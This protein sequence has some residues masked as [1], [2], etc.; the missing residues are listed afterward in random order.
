MLEKNDAALIIGDPGMSFPRQG[1]KRLGYGGVSGNSTPDSGLFLRC[2]W[3]E[4]MRSSAPRIADF[5]GARDEGV[6]HI[7][8]II[9]SYQDKIPMRV[10]E[11]RNYLTENIVFKSR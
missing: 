5:S 8:E 7:E 4:R 10:D 6:A 11:L 9:H 3:S 1:V 2:G